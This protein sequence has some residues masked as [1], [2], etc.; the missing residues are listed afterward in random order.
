MIVTTREIVFTCGRCVA[1][2]RANWPK[3][4][5]ITSAIP[6]VSARHVIA[7]VRARSRSPL[8]A[9]KSQA[10]LRERAAT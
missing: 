3:V 5:I 9:F 10:F 8:R 4:T 2:A 7:I 6:R 1:A